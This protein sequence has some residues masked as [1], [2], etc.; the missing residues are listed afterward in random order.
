MLKSICPQ[1]CP[2][3]FCL[4]ACPTGAI[5]LAVKGKRENICIDIDKCHGCGICR[6]LCITWSKDK[7]LE[8]KLPWISSASD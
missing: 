5:T 8:R 2:A 6:M 7:S 3:P 4:S 1:Y